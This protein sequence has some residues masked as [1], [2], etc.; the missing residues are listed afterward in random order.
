MQPLNVKR[1]RAT[2]GRAAH[3]SV[4]VALPSD[5]KIIGGGAGILTDGTAGN[6]LTASFPLDLQ[7]W[8]AE[9]KDH[10][11]SDPQQIAAVVIAIEDP[12][13]EWDVT[14]VSQASAPTSH[15]QAIAVLPRDP[16]YILTGGGA[17]VDYKG[18]GNLLTASCPDP[19][20]SDTSWLARSKDHDVPDP[21]SIT[22][23]AIG[24]R[25]R[26]GTVQLERVLRH[27]T[28]SVDPHPGIFASIEP[29]W[30]LSGGGAFD[31]WESTG[32]EGNLLTKSTPSLIPMGTPPGGWELQWVASG[33]D[34]LRS[35]PASITAF[36]I[37]IRSP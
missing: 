15:P 18:A 25:H 4:V 37:G 16:R 5:F 27:S 14:I 20:A 11:V 19:N 6:F 12:Q 35:S 7:T 21:A 3:P 23:Y 31:D 36:A 9:A 28:S 13:D 32:G 22:A 24:M 17:F 34:H 2:S 1:F 30:I 8:K 29:G 33:T 26:A 10:E